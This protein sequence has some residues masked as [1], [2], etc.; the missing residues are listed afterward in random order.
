MF[1]NVV[2][3]WELWQK[4][5]GE[6]EQSLPRVTRNGKG[7]SPRGVAVNFVSLNEIRSKIA[8][9]RDLL[10]FSPCDGSATLLEV[11]TTSRI[12]YCIFARSFDRDSDVF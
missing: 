3:A 1:L 12:L 2:C 8:C 11:K 10:D 7:G 9:F 6:R 5:G 4:G